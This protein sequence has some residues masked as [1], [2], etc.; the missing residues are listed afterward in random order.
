ME[1]EPGFDIGAGFGGMDFLDVDGMMVGESFYTEEC[2]FFPPQ[3]R[4]ITFDRPIRTIIVWIDM[5]P[6][7]IDTLSI[8]PPEEPD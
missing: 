6:V 4:L 1:E 3:P 5:E 7:W 8:N 2:W